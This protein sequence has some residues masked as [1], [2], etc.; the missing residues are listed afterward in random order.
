MWV[1]RWLC[2]DGYREPSLEIKNSIT[3]MVFLA[4]R[5]PYN[6][7]IMHSDPS[8]VGT[9]VIHCVCIWGYK[10]HYTG[11]FDRLGLEQ[12]N[13]IQSSVCV[14]GLWNCVLSNKI[15]KT[16]GFAGSPL[17][18]L[19]LSLSYRGSLRYLTQGVKALRLGKDVKLRCNCIAGPTQRRRQTTR[20]SSN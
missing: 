4:K 11:G 13:K 8:M 9:P 15:N 1:P 6:R 12:I 7:R 5:K 18:H 20:T 3:L 2:R 19:S 10:S 17:P 16:L 14:W